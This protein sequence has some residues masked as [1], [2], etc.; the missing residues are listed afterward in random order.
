MKKRPI[1]R[2]MVAIKAKALAEEDQIP[3]GHG[4]MGRFFKRKNLS[5]RRKT[6]TAQ[7]PPSDYHE[8]IRSFVDF[9][10]ERRKEKNYDLGAII[11]CDETAVWLDMVPNTTVETIGA[12]DVTVL[13]TGH[14]KARI[15]VML[16][17]CSDGRKLKPF[18]LLD[19][20]RPIK[21]LAIFQ[22]KLTIEYAGTT[23]MNEEL[24]SRYIDKVIGRNIFNSQRRLFVWDSFRCHISEN[25]K[26]KL[27]SLNVDM[28]VVPGGCTKFVQPADVSWNNP[29][30]EKIRQYYTEW[31][32]SDQVEMTKNGNPRPPSLPTVCQWVID[33]WASLSSD[34]IRKSFNSCGIT[35]ALD[36]SEDG[37]IT[38]LKTAESF[39]DFCDD[40]DE[41]ICF[42]NENI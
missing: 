21:E 32:S 7:R 9:I 25:I 30:K 39:T 3:R 20:K 2:S 15:T 26:N 33:A 10:K 1:S 35:V 13:S 34:L 31:I 22:S 12:K 42:D 23:W 29:F 14:E 4:W 11:G 6:T 5:L 8:Q 37:Q 27:N 41:I 19:R 24:T 38:A 16:S 28:A 18:I 17:A 40:D 36:G